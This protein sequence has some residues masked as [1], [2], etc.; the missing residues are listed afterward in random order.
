MNHL[1]LQPTP[2][3]SK[4]SKQTFHMEPKNRITLKQG[5]IFSLRKDSQQGFDVRKCRAHPN[6]VCVLLGALEIFSGMQMHIQQINSYVHLMAFSKHYY[7]V[8]M[9]GALHG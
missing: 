3:L 4:A 7:L 6:I 8:C 1:G 9:L 2:M 5:S